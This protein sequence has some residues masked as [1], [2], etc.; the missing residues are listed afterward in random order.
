[1]GD[2]NKKEVVPTNSEDKPENTL[3]FDDNIDARRRGI[4]SIFDKEISKERLFR[5]IRGV[6]G[7]KRS[8][9]TPPDEILR[10]Y[11]LCFQTQQGSPITENLWTEMRTWIKEERYYVRLL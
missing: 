10:R 9:N 6:V 3:S 5:L 8:L 2:G 7:Q 4:V 1:M 11:H